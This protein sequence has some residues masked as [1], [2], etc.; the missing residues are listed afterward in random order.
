V[1]PSTPS[2]ANDFIA[3]LLGPKLTEAWSQPVNVDNRPGAGGI[4]GAEIVARAPADGHTLLV[5]ATGFALNPFLYSKLPYDTVKDF[6]AVS[7]VASTTHVL[8]LHPSLPARSVKEL[9]ALARARPGQ[10]TYATSGT[11]TGGF[12]CAE[13]M[14]SMTRIDM[15]G[16][17]Y[18]G[19]GAASAAVLSGEVGMLF[20]Q[21]APVIQQVRASRL[22]PLATTSLT[23][24]REL[25][26]VPTMSESGLPGF[27]VDAW[28]GLLAPGA[29][30]AEI[31]AKLQEQV[32]RIVQL[33]DTRERLAGG[34]FEP[35]ASTPAAFA[36]LIRNDMTRWSKL[37][38]D[39]GIKPEAAQ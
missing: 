35:V 36:A 2:G 15:V 23:R 21:I 10:L 6:A 14:K 9:L 3:R 25:P 8:V 24:A 30:P 39:A 27:S 33:P 4:I 20:T 13:L 7:L 12:L 18:K 22:R 37:I 28:T 17:P 1:V 32:A 34:G 31:V 26:D 19:A 5:V 11:G 29:T 38:R 16:I